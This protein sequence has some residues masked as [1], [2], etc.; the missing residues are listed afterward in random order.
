MYNKITHPS[1]GK[2]YS[3]R[4]PQGRKIIQGYL[5]Y[6]KGGSNKTLMKL[7]KQ[8][9]NVQRKVVTIQNKI[10]NHMSF[11]EFGG[12]VMR[13]GADPGPLGSATDVDERRILLELLGLEKQDEEGF[14]AFLDAAERGQWIR[15]QDWIA[16]LSA[17]DAF[18]SL[19]KATR[20]R[21]QWDR[22]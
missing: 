2:S 6:A 12:E 1:S 14:N 3:I 8:L 18:F 20:A 19:L 17:P 10:N 16:K 22:E 9:K 4:S 21:D 15:V 13:G 5:S 11:S 7:R